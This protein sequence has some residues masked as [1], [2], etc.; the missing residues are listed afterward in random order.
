MI[1]RGGRGG[2]GSGGGRREAGEKEEGKKGRK[3]RKGRTRKQGGGIERGTVRKNDIRFKVDI[4]EKG[5]AALRAAPLECR[6]ALAP[7]ASLCAWD[8]TPTVPRG[9]E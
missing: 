2:G 6:L 3:G 8:R 5:A 4:E 1:V 9:K 7:G